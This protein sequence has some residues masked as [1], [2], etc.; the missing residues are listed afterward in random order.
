[1]AKIRI[2]INDCADGEVEA[3]LLIDAPLPKER[4]RWSPAQ[5]LAFMIR[6]AI[7]N[8]PEL[9]EDIKRF[10]LQEAEQ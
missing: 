1:M 8:D 3:R 4:R 9:I 7:H 5:K 10:Q 6:G 2:E